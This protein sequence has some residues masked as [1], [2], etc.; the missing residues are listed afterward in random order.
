MPTN[1]DVAF[2]KV[3]QFGRAQKVAYFILAFSFFVTA[4]PSLLPVIIA[5]APQVICTSVG[6]QALGDNCKTLNADDNYCNYPQTY[7]QVVPTRDS[8]ASEW[9]LLCDQR[10]KIGKTYTYS[11]STLIFVL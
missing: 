2:H 5:S 6:R 4:F 11:L 1:I 8:I 9:K 3:G 10:W 7:W